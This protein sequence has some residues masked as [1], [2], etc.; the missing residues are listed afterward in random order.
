[1]KTFFV[2][3]KSS[4]FLFWAFSCTSVATAFSSSVASRPR[5]AKPFHFSSR[6]HFTYKTSP[7]P[8]HTAF[9]V[10]RSNNLMLDTDGDKSQR[11]RSENFSHSQ[12]KENSRSEKLSS[13]FSVVVVHAPCQVVLRANSWTEAW[14]L[15]WM[16]KCDCV[17][18]I[19]FRYFKAEE[20]K[21]TRF[22]R[23]L[24]LIECKA[25]FSLSNELETWWSF[26]GEWKWDGW[27]NIYL[28]WTREARPSLNLN[29]DWL[30]LIVFASPFFSSFSCTRRWV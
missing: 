5:M 15:A 23:S 24:I 27:R 26:G 6:L 22:L 9:I 12:E 17:I 7:P 19:L 1:M 8:T 13:F 11:K 28:P 4:S 30:W 25:S 29:V 14:D 3:I 10:S 20:K 18:S 2:E 21:K 16:R